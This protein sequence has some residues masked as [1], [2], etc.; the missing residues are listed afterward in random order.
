MS[1]TLT[2]RFLNAAGRPASGWVYF[3][4]S[5]SPTL[6]DVG[7]FVGTADRIRLAT[8][9]SLTVT[10]LPSTPGLF[11]LI[12]P[13]IVTGDP[14]TLGPVTIPTQPDGS[15]L[16]LGDLI[17]DW[18]STPV[19]VPWELWGPVLDRL[20]TIEAGG[21]GSDPNAVKLTGDQTI[22]GV[23]TFTDAP[24]VPDSAFT[25][26]KTIGLQAA[27]DGKA[28]IDS[29]TFTGSVTLPAGAINM[30]SVGG[31]SDALAANVTPGPQYPPEPFG[32]VN[33]TLL[34]SA[35]S[36]NNE[37]TLP[38][39]VAD[40]TQLKFSDLPEPGRY[41]YFASGGL[42]TTN[43]SNDV[44]WGRPVITPGQN[45]GNIGGAPSYIR[46]V[47]NSPWVLLTGFCGA[48]SPSN[49]PFFVK[50]N[51]QAVWDQPRILP[52]TWS[53]DVG[54]MHMTFTDTSTKLIEVLH[55]WMI[56][57]VNYETGSIM[58]PPTEATPLKRLYILGDSWIGGTDQ[59]GAWVSLARYVQ[60][61]TPW[62]VSING[63]G[64]TGYVQGLGEAWNAPY[65]DARRI[66]AITEY[67]PDVLVVFGSIN[68]WGAAG[69]AAAVDTFYTQV[70][71]GAP[72]TKIIVIGPQLP[73]TGHASNMDLLRARVAAFPQ[74]IGVVD[75]VAEGWTIQGIVGR[76]GTSFTDPQHPTARGVEWLGKQVTGVVRRITQDGA[77][78]TSW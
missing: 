1:W 5:T 52:G 18:P 68:D 12:Y 72:N 77:G 3:G 13:R 24:V 23:K 65:T 40:G 38:H 63:Q 56:E 59:A 8:D 51:G 29:P 70:T 54:G 47:T 46:F 62:D 57:A 53:G 34:A 49:W 75:P 55:T 43:T 64:G 17:T 10:G 7:T 6:T 19:F 30:A 48:G 58:N 39:T 67:K 28:P 69:Y 9:G 73:G 27:L 36:H 60:A 78:D 2:H 74:V 41:D 50:I 31:L 35:T 61:A 44:M 33:P 25:V 22:T 45:R 71:A 15:T 42:F 14:T 66:G 37:A 26:A 4:L 76:E 32:P 21:G 11:L 20:D 16:N